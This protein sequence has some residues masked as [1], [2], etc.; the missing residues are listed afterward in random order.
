[1]AIEYG[2]SLEAPPL[3]LPAFKRAVEDPNLRAE[4]EFP[5]ADT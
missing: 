1:M 2:E 5:W 3:L 4:Q